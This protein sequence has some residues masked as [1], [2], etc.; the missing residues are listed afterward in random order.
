MM[1]QLHVKTA[2]ESVCV[3]PP[4]TNQSYLNMDAILDAIQKTG[5]Q[6]VCILVIFIF[7]SMFRVF[8]ILFSFPFLPLLNLSPFSSPF[9]L[10]LFFSSLPASLFHFLI[11]PLSFNCSCFPTSLMI[12]FLL[13]FLG[14]PR[15][16]I[17]F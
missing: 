5:A 13:S 9:S 12:P 11:V 7:L 8:S 4:P 16:W 14:P 1:F 2:D 10:S 6:A 17:S 15:V 3:G